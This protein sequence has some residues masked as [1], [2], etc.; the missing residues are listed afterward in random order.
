MG[1]ETAEAVSLEIFSRLVVNG[2]GRGGGGGGDCCTTDLEFECW[3]KRMP[4]GRLGKFKSEGK[5]PGE[6][7]MV[8]LSKE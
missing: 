8:M 7:K 5:T 3:V 2:I 4:Q 1:G 6:M